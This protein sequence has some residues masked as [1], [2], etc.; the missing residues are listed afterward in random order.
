MLAQNLLIALHF[1]YRIQRTLQ[2][3]LIWPLLHL[4]PYIHCSLTSS[5]PAIVAC[6]FCRIFAMAVPSAWS[7]LPPGNGKPQ[8]LTLNWSLLKCLNVT[9]T[10]AP[11]ASHWVIVSV[12]VSLHYLFPPLK[13]KAM[14]QEYYFCISGPGSNSIHARIC[15][16]IRYPLIQNL[17]MWVFW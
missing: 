7:V 1:V 14:R 6:L 5:V 12:Y 17:Q 13:Y 4:C 3:C 15:K 10:R 9:F 8:L 2:S 11:A 16:W